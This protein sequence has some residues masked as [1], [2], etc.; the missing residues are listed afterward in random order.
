MRWRVEEPG[1]LGAFLKGRAEGRSWNELKRILASG[2]VFV[3]GERVVAPT[4]RV[5]AGQTVEL[6]MAAP[7]PRDPRSEVRLVHEDPHLVVIDKPSGVSSV[8]FEKKEAGTA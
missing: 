6:R 1:T 7:R 4:R 8:P 3:D 5:R 2:K